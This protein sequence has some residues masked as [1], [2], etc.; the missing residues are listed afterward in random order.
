MKNEDK[1]VE[2]LSDM[3]VK[4]D[5]FIEE[6]RE[7]KSIQKRQETHLIKM[8]EILSDDVPKF[9]ELLDVEFMKDGK[10]IILKKHR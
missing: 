2:L 9:D 3:V 4:Q 8:L 6:L 7:V 10:Q 1:I 5:T